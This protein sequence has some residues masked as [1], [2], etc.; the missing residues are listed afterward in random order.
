MN[1]GTVESTRAFLP[2]DECDQPIECKVM[3]TM[4]QLPSKDN[5]GQMLVGCRAE[6][7]TEPLWAHFFLFHGPA[8]PFC[9]P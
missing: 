5:R 3:L 1:L 8:D 2:C 9:D 4:I 6:I 7:N